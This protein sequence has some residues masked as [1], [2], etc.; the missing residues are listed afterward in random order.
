MTLSRKTSRIYMDDYDLTGACNVLDRRVTDHEKCEATPY[1]GG[2]LMALEILL[3]H[4]DIRDQ[5]VFMMLFDAELDE[6]GIEP[7]RPI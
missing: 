3:T 2:A 6:A 4:D 5:S 1:Y 7:I